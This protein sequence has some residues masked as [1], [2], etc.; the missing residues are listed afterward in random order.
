MEYKSNSNGTTYELVFQG[1][2]SFSDNALI[3]SIVEEIN[4]S[5]C[6]IC[7]IDVSSLTSIDSAGLGMLLFINDSVSENGTRLEVHGA[8]GQVQK[9]LEISKFSEIISIKP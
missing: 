5:G 9:M 3:R 4:K 8:T 2:F 1:K 7:S 6:T